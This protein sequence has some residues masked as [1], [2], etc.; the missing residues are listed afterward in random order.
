MLRDSVGEDA[1]EAGAVGK[2]VRRMLISAEDLELLRDEI[3]YIMENA[4]RNISK[5]TTIIVQG[6]RDP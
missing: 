4:S 2:C 6:E 5:D 1:A 3:V